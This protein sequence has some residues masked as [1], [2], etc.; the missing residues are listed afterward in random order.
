MDGIK[1]AR[2]YYELFGK[3]MIEENFSEYKDRIAVGL[4]GH[5]SECFGFDDEI[6]RDH[7]YE[8]G[9]CLWIT[10]E[11]EKEFGFKLFRAYSKLPDEFNGVKLQNKSVFG[12]RFKGVHTINEFY[13]FYTGHGDVPRTNEEWLNIPSF[14]LAEA[15]NGEVFYDKYGEFSRIRDGLK[16][17]YPEDVKF[18]KLASSLFCCAQTGQYNYK[19]CFMHGEKGAAALALADFVKNYIS[20]VFL[21]NNEYE[22]YYKWVFKAL[23]KQKYLSETKISL[24]N[25]LSSSYN[26]NDNIDVIE[27]LSMKLIDFMRNNGIVNGAGD[28]LE[29]YAY[30]INDKISDGNLRNMPVIL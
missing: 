23:E 1:L 28:Y 3:P 9:F 20:A 6:S 8:P 22:P 5:G 2:E 29:G 11:D 26:F 15:T 10:D 4:V 7:D 24:E 12:S 21:L 17:G 13:S 19:R 30:E 18:K 25:L 16:K 14:Y 27:S